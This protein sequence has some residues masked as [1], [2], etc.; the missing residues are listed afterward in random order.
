MPQY[1]VLVATLTPTKLL[2][3][4]CGKLWATHYSTAE[5][6]AGQYREVLNKKKSLEQLRDKF[7]VVT[8]VPYSVARGYLAFDKFKDNRV[9]P[10][11]TQ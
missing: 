11:P 1:Y 5:V 2:I 9:T 7:L 4:K 3:E 6:E 10:R 8:A